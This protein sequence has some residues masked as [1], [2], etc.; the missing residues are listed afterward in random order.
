[1]Q[2]LRLSARPR[3]RRRGNRALRDLNRRLGL[4]PKT[5]SWPMP[6]LRFNPTG[7]APPTDTNLAYARH[8]QFRGYIGFRLSVQDKNGLVALRRA[9]SCLVLSTSAL[10][11]VSQFPCPGLKIPLSGSPNSL[12]WVSKFPPLGLKNPLAQGIRNRRAN[13]RQRGCFW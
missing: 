11:W 12:D 2:V 8:E 10:H 1:M 4:W 13:A 3:N 9:R 6:S 7:F 5:A